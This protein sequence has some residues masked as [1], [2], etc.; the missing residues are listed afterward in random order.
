MTALLVMNL[1]Q[2]KEVKRTKPVKKT[3]NV[4]GMFDVR[5]L[6]FDVGC[7]LSVEG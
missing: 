4:V 5:G 7:E 3:D 6:R 2:S 1:S